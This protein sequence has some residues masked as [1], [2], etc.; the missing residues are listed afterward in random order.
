MMFPIVWTMLLTG[1]M[2]NAWKSTQIIQKSY[3]S[4]QNQCNIKFGD[5]LIG[6][7]CIRFSKEVKNVA[8]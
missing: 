1:L 5:T 2:F 8:V 6:D 3:S 7:D 4:T